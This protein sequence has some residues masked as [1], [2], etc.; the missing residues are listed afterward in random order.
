MKKHFVTFLSPGTFVAEQNVEE[1][2]S[3]DVDSAKRRA[4]V[5]TQRYSATPYGFY[6]TTM[7]RGEEDW[8]PKQTAKSPMYYVNCRVETLQEIEARDDPKESILRSNMRVNGWDRIVVTTKGWK[9]TQPL[10][11]SD[12]VL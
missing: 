10:E 4:E 12:V 9:W 6:F 2:E 7:E 5:I 3:W 1:V 8:M 11:A